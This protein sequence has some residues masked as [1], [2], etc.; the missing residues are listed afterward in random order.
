MI[1]N[2]VVEQ[3]RIMKDEIEIEDV[4]HLSKII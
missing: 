4:E 1:I 2:R 3:K